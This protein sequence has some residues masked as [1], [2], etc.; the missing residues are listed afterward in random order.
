M[1][2]EYV[3][4]GDPVGHSRSPAIH[5]AAFAELGIDARYQARR[6]DTS[7]MAGAAA[8]MRR[9]ELAGANITMPHKELAFRLVD[10]VAGEAQVA[11]SVNTWVIAGGELV[12]HSTDIPGIRQVWERRNLDDGPVLILG[13][14]GAASAALVALAGRDLFLSARRGDAAH[15]LVEE[16]GST[17]TVVPWGEGREAVVVNCTPVGMRGET[18]PFPVL[19]RATGLLE[20]AYGWEPTPAETACRERGKPVADGIDLLVAQAACSF[21]LWLNLPAPLAEME[22]AARN[23]SRPQPQGPNQ[24]PS[25]GRRMR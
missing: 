15:R 13:S 8:Q 14:G 21:E 2:A 1:P 19:E 7:G 17:A 6:V 16:V 5:N 18:L 9:G 23:G 10:R 4:L 24:P 12:G 20:M 22:R 11:A 25:Q 3:V